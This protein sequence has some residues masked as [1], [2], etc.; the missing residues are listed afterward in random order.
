RVMAEHAR[1]GGRSPEGMTLTVQLWNAVKKTTENR[2]VPYEELVREGE[3]LTPHEAACASCPA[4]FRGTPFGCFG[5]VN[6]PVPREAEEWLLGRLEPSTNL[7]GKLFLRAIDDFGYTGDPIR[8]LRAG[9]LFESKDSLWRELNPGPM[10]GD[11][12]TSDQLFQAIF[13]ISEPLDPGHCLGILLWLGALTLDGAPARELPQLRALLDL[14]TP[15]ER[16]AR[17]GLDQGEGD[18]DA[19]EAMQT[20]LRAIY[21][22]WALDAPL[23]VW[24]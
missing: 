20:M 17:A 3:R 19:V 1:K 10:G 9:G 7:G 8:R 23:N 2:E 15:E 24:A 12:V 22:S 11:G 21:L 13:C 16:L 18:S 4:N 5:W 14:L 6:Y